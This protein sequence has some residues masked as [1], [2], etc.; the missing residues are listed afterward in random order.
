[1][2]ATIQTLFTNW[3]NIGT[4]VAA[5]VI[6]FYLMWAGYLLLTSSGNP[7]QVLRAKEAFWHAIAGGVIVLAA[8]TLAGAITV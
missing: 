6:A 2:Q 7:Q 3:L 4:A 1:M 5:I 8:R